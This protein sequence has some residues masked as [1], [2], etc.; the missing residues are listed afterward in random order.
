MMRVAL[1]G[2]GGMGKVHFDEYMKNPDT[3]VVAVADVRVDMAKEKVNNE[4]IKIYSSIDELLENEDVDMVDIATPSYLHAEHSIKALEAGKHVLCEKP[5]SVSLDG[6][7]K[8]REAAEKSEKMLMIAHVVRFMSPYRYLKN[9]IDSRELGEI[10]HI[11]MKR[12]SSIPRWSWENWMRDL[13]KSGGDTID[14]AIHDI[15]FLQYIFGM[16]KDISGVYSKL[17][18]DNDFISATLVYDGFTATIESG[19]FNCEMPFCAEYSA[20][21]ENGTLEYKG[22]K[23]YKNGEEIEIDKSD[24]S[25]VSGIN[26]KGADGYSAEIAYFVSSILNGTKPETVTPESSENSIRLAKEIIKNSIVL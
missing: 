13:E 16:P 12:V 1:I 2:I 18:N 22:D 6:T 20:V 17:K 8:M 3:E 15:D 25:E 7:A 5:M 23:L 26:I 11:N 24:M 19:W 10:V 9:V 21:F 14:M 4:N